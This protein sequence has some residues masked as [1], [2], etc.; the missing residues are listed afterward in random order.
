MN[1][2]SLP[3][4]HDVLEL[5]RRLDDASVGADGVTTQFLEVRNELQSGGVCVNGNRNGLIHLARLTLEVAAK[6]FVGAHQHL[7]A[8]GEV[9]NCEVPLT[10]GLKP[11]E[12]DVR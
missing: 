1:E 11:A 12:W 9:D 6:D 8:D 7:D 4:I 10:I 5:L 2:L 3:S